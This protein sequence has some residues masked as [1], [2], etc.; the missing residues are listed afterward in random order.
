[1]KIGFYLQNNGIK[2]VNCRTPEEGNP[3]IGGTEYLFIAIP[4][5]L[6]VY[7]CSHEVSL[8]ANSIENLPSGLETVHVPVD[9]DIKNNLK[10]KDLDYLVVRYSPENFELIH[11]LPP[12]SR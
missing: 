4:Y 7:G 5:A 12:Q 1:M 3:G 2:G 9:Q 8:I 10:V 6:S 11:T